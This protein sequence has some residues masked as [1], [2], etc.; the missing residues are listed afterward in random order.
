MECQLAHHGILGMKWGIRRTPQQ[1][2]HEP[3]KPKK[4][5]KVSELSDEELR[6]RISRLQME[7]NYTN[8]V[9]RQKERNTSGLRKRAS[10]ALT[11]LGEKGLEF[12]VNQ[13]AKK[14][15]SASDDRT[16]NDFAEIDTDRMDA[17]TIAKVAKM[18][19]QAKIINTDRKEKA[20]AFKANEEAAKAEKEKAKAE[21][22][23]EKARRKTEARK[24]KG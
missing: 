13:V 11:S 4:K 5:V 1:L 9:A 20:D 18:V 16:L 12:A 3:A 14:L 19:T 22:A 15:F 21:K 23:A 2:G 24:K 10:K 6:Q 8:L 7:E 17:D